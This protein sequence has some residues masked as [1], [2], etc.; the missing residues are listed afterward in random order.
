MLLRGEIATREAVPKHGKGKGGE[1]VSSGEQEV[2]RELS[3]TWGGGR[4]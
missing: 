4:H 3:K 1:R 2:P